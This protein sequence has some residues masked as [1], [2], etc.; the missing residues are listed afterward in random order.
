MWESW[1]ARKKSEESPH[2]SRVRMNNEVNRKPQKENQE[3]TK[4]L[5]LIQTIE[6]NRAERRH[7]YEHNGIP[8][9]MT[10]S[11]EILHNR[12]MTPLE[13]QNHTT[14]AASPGSFTSQGDRMMPLCL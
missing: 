1:E 4:T 2:M 13:L 3:T 6:N 11:H 7:H 8:V 9:Q 12:A 14:L 10:V 5:P